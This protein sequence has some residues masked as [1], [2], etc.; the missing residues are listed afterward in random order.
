VFIC[1]TPL[2]PDGIP[3]AASDDDPC[4]DG[5]AVD[6]PR[7]C[8]CWTEIF[9]LQQASDL[10]EGLPLPAVPLRPCEPGP[11]DDGC[12]Y[13]G[14]SPEKTGSS[15][16]SADA[17]ELDRLAATGSP[18]FCH[19]GIRR[20]THMRHPSGLTWELPHRS[21]YRPPIRGNVPYRADGTPA[22]ICSGWLLRRMVLTRQQQEEVSAGGGH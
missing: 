17:D 22:S 15:G 2:L 6:G 13:L 9:D 7:G 21:D 18:F 10:H 20:V 19:N 4:C 11:G 5:R 12:A 3:D 8:G 16:H 1:G 14:T